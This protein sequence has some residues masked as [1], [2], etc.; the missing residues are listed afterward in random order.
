MATDHIPVMLQEVLTYLHPQDYEIYIDATFGSGGYTRAFLEAAAC[1]V[2]AFDRDPEAILR[3]KDLQAR[4]GKRLTIIEAPFSEIA[5]QL[6]A[7]GIHK[8]NGIVFDL[9]VS[10]PQIDEPERGFSLRFE[11]PLHMRMDADATQLTAH[12]VVN[13]FS[14]QDIA[15]ILYRYGDERK[16][17]RIAKAIVAARGNQEIA[18]TLQLADLVKSVMPAHGQV[19]HPATRTF[20]ALRIFVN[21]E[22]GE[23]E[24]ALAVT[25]QILSPGGRLLVVTFHSL[26]DRLIKEFL[27]P[28]VTLRNS[29]YLPYA[30][31]KE[32]LF[33]NLMKKPLTPSKQEIHHNPR[34]R[35]AKLRAAVFKGVK[36]L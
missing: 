13:Q 36:T 8:V 30:A 1:Q 12:A 4:F 31:H 34:A 20:Q 22:L 14:E 25:P 7:R 21:D 18:T 16:S 17:R 3:A 19:E 26:E 2:I 9:G 28:Q 15:D 29:R 32:P 27:H 6:S 35:S 23:F 24:R 11:G 5:T 33:E 10:S